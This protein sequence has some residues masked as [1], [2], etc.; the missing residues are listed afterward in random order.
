MALV[1]VALDQARVVLNDTSSPPK[2]Y[3]NTILLPHL[4]EA[5]R[6]LQVLL[7][8][9][10]L[11]VIKEVT[12]VIDVAALATSLG[13]SLPTDILEP[14]ALQERVD[15]STTEDDWKDVS[16]TDNLPRMDPTISIQYWAWREES[17]EFIAPTTAREVKLR[18]LKG[19]TLPTSGSSA[20]G[21]IFGELYLGPRLASIAVQ[22]LG[23][24]TRASELIDDAAFWIPK[25]LAANVKRGQAVPTR[26]I[27]YRRSLRRFIVGGM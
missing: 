13:V 20:I 2:F 24:T 15:G 10:G 14:K 11:P 27:P 16:E 3:T 25:I 26:R 22:T 7:W 19:L 12:A 9:N 23:N 21:L 6:E 18:Y 1:S 5:H 4:K 17:I 8:E